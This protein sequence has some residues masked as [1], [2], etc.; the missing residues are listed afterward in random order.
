MLDTIK[1]KFTEGR[2][3]KASYFR[4]EYEKRSYQDLSESEKRTNNPLP[5]RK[6][7]LNRNLLDEY[8]PSVEVTEKLD[9]EKKKVVR[10][11]LVECSV[12]KL[13]RENNLIEIDETDYPLFVSMLKNKLSMVGIIFS[14]EQIANAG[15]TKLH[16]SKNVILPNK[17]SI[18]DIISQLRTTEMGK[19][20]DASEKRHVPTKHGKMHVHIRNKDEVFTHYTTTRSYVFYDKIRDMQKPKSKSTDKDKTDYEKELLEIYNLYHKEILRF[21]YRLT[22]YTTVHS[23][24]NAILHRSYDTEVQVRDIFSKHLWES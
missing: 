20:Y 8:C 16:A 24:I 18:D 14:E 12:P 11:V 10:E 9:K 22:A 7:K 15:I 2:I 4:P 5:L 23:E 19:S 13:M 21:E 17:Y 1:I 3:S 6:Y